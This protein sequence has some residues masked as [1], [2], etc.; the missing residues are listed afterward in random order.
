MPYGDPKYPIVKPAPTVDDCIRAMR[1]RD[2]FVLGGVTAASYAFGFATGRPL[3]R[4][5]ASLGAT[6]GLTF[7]MIVVLQDTR[8][9]LMGY[10][11]NSREV[12]RY[13][14]APVQIQERERRPFPAVQ[15]RFSEVTRPKIDWDRY[16]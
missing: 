11:E 14:K 8:D 16:K 15:P 3:R 13:G 5:F 10:K 7:G 4:P 6:I 12:S 1:I 9:R 2:Y